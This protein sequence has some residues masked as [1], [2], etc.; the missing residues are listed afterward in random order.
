VKL[1]EMLDLI[2]GPTMLDDRVERLSGASDELVT[3]E[4]IVAY[5]NEAQNEL[6]SEA[7]VLEDLTT[8]A[9][10]EIQLKLDS[11]DYPLHEAILGVKYIRLSDSDVDLLRVGYHDNRLHNAQPLN[12]PD[13]WDV[14]WPES[15]TSGRPTRWSADVGSRMLRL[16]SKPNAAAALL[17]AKLA[18]IR[19]PVNELSTSNPQAEPEVPKLYHMPMCRYAAAKCVGGDVDNG[20]AGKARGWLSEWSA[21][22]KKATRMKAR[23][24]MAQPQW[25]FGGWARGN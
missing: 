7:W 19:L 17:K 16:R 24:Q 3:D 9:V 13:Y 12:E 23:L 18:V 25:R 1:R 22:I 14:N 5:L 15:E 4:T 2:G 8:P 10:C 11:T 6:A 20:L 21:T